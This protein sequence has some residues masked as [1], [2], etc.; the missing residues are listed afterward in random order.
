MNRTEL[1]LAPLSI[2]GCAMLCLL[3]SHDIGSMMLYGWTNSLV[4]ILT[5]KLRRTMDAVFRD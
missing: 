2:Y 3:S 4:W 1:W 5:I